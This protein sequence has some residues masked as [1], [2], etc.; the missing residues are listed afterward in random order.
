L[1][2]LRPHQ[3]L[4]NVLVFL[5][6][7]TAN[8]LRD[9]RAWVAAAAM[10]IAFC[11]TASAVYIVNDVT[12]LATDR[13]HPRKRK[14]PF[15]SGDLPL[16][17]GLAVAPVLLLSG[18]AL[19]L[20]VGT[21]HVIVFYAACSLAYS[22][23][24]K[25]LPLVDIFTLALLYTLRLFG[26]AEA[27]SYRLSPWLLVFSIFLF[28]GLATIKRVG[29]LLDLKRQEG[30]RTDRRGYQTEDIAILQAMGVGASFVSVTVLALFVQ[31]DSVAARYT[32]PELLWVIVP[33]VL[34]W[35]CRLWLSTAR[36]YMPD[37][38]IVN[39]AQDWVSRLIAATVLVIFLLA[40]G[41]NS[42]VG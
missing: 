29:E 13:R 37:D 22:I 23:K 7:I 26:G 15:A 9:G 25:E 14:R 4:K 5:P 31:A 6:I 18:I 12:D 32:H 30:R 11:A 36:G 10:F 17:V 2:A 20:A 41:F 16:T 1:K 40:R 35:Q 3:W 24:L 28:L 33:L 19:S 42:P 21:A 27:S 34:F 39:A 8:A 38:P